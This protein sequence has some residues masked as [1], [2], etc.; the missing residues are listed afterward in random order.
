MP[1]VASPIAMFTLSPI[2][3]Q[4]TVPWMAWS[5]PSIVTVLLPCAEAAED[6]PPEVSD[7]FSEEQPARPAITIAAPPTAT[8]N[9]RFTTISFCRRGPS[10]SADRPTEY[11]GPP[12][13]GLGIAGKFACTGPGY[14]VAGHRSP[15]LVEYTAWRSRLSVSM[16]SSRG[17]SGAPV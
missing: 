4:T 15:R 17:G 2:V 3:L 1:V 10:R 8:T 7:F 9:P 13:G 6:V 14:Q 12:S 11:G 16:R 5:L